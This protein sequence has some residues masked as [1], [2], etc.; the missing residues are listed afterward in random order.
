MSIVIRKLGRRSLREIAVLTV[1]LAATRSGVS[2]E[3]VRADRSSPT[4]SHSLA[5]P[6]PETIV[7]IG[8]RVA[9]WQLAQS[10]QGSGDQAFRTWITSTF[11]TGLLK[12]ADVTAQDKYFDA[13]LHESE[14][15]EWRLGRR[16]RHADDHL[17]GYV[18][19]LLFQRYGEP[20]MIAPMRARFD[21]LA[22]LPY[23]E[24]LTWQ[25]NI[26]DREWAWCDALF[27]AP[28]TMWQLSAITGDPKYAN[29]ADRLWWKTTDYLFDPQ[30]NLFFRDDRYFDRREPN[31]SKLFWSRGNGW[32]VGGLVRVLENM[33][34]DDPRRERYLD[35]Y[36]RMVRRLVALQENNGCWPAGLLDAQTWDQPESSGTALY[37]YA[38]AWGIN[39]GVLNRDRYLPTVLKGWNALV[40]CVQPSGK[41]GWVQRVDDSPH[42]SGPDQTGAYASGG[43]LLLASELYK[44]SLFD[45]ATRVSLAAANSLD[46]LRPD[47]TVTVPWSELQPRLGD[48]P[49]DAVSLLDEQTGSIVLSQRMAG[50]GERQ[51]EELLF[52]ADFRPGQTKAFT[53]YR[54]KGRT[55]PPQASRVF[56]RAVPERLDDF[57]WESDRIAYRVYGPALAPAND[58]GSGVDVWVKKVRYPII[59]TWYAGDDYHVDH[60][61]GFDGYKVG[62]SRAAGGTGLLYD[63]R[64][65]ISGLYTKA[66]RLANGPLRVCF[67]LEYGP[68]D[69]PD[70]RVAETKRISLDA[71][72]NLNHV[73]AQFSVDGNETVL[74]LAIGLELQG[75]GGEVQSGAH[76]LGYWGPQQGENGRTGVGLVIIDRPFAVK[77][78]RQT[79]RS[80][81]GEN[82][83]DETNE[84]VL[85]VTS[86]KPGEPFSYYVGAG[87]SQ[88]RD[89][90]SAADWFRHLAQAAER[91][92]SPIVVSVKD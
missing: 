7:A 81:L 4:G 75:E 31:G 44:L 56:G 16:P 10:R 42:S 67:E 50:G 48:P 51:P 2:A 62:K 21:E 19:G 68:W 18:Y 70:G 80:G 35:L 77:Q 65:Y 3:P 30:E 55:A 63:D 64:L 78:H 52:Q 47:E 12:F 66:T 28:P 32:V 71:N 11:Y 43:F 59:D 25:N 34:Q 89:F 61:E 58:A 29:Q 26:A 83:F 1:C 54:L 69:T 76:W 9:D 72:R 73:T 36:R 74:P 20:Q 41:V 90:A 49:V 6:A 22:A 38:I 13:T 15:N 87:W 84:E 5:L 14:S 82:E 8:T 40:K 53:V 91:L 79:R 37:T 24:P 46:V 88:S 45:G 92:G 17:V 33:P 39:H 86:V 57:A 60:G 27:M 23:D 85:A